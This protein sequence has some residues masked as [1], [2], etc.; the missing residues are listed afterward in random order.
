VWN[1]ILFLSAL[2]ACCSYAFWRGGAPERVGAAIFILATLL[3]IATAT[4]LRPAFKSLEAGILAVDVGVFVAFL[5]LALRSRRFWPL[6]MTAFQGVQV[7]G[8]AAQLASPEMMPWVYSVAQ[9]IWSYPMMAILA[10][11]TWRHQRR[12]RTNAQS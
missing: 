1:V 6:W 3:T 12:Q 10:V 11:G 8:H 2:T 4:S 9:G 7:A 5:L